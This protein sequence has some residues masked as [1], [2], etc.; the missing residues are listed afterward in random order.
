MVL[1]TVSAIPGIAKAEAEP[2]AMVP[3]ENTVI[4]E[5]MPA[6]NLVLNLLVFFIVFTPFEFVL[7]FVVFVFSVLVVVVFVV[8]ILVSPFGFV[9]LL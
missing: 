8:F 6:I 4:A 9:F 3:T 5:R 1:S 7:L 2:I